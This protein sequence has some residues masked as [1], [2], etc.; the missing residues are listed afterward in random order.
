MKKEMETNKALFLRPSGDEKGIVNLFAS[1]SSASSRLQL[2]PAG[3]ACKELGLTPTCLSLDTSNVNLID[4]I[5]RPKIC[6]AG[7]LTT[8]GTS[9]RNNLAMAHLAV[10]GRLKAQRIPLIALYSDHQEYREESIRELHKDLLKLAD[11]IVFPSRAMYKKATNWISTN[12]K[13]AII[14]DPW[15][16]KPQDFY[17]IPTETIEII[18]FGHESNL[19]YL[20]PILTELDRAIP[21]NRKAVLTIL[22][23]LYGLNFIKKDLQAFRKKSQIRL[24]LIPWN[25]MQQ[26]QQL[27]EELGR[28]QFCILPSNA[29]DPN[30]SAASHN[31]LVDAIRSGCI[32]IATPLENYKELGG[33]CLLS[34]NITKSLASAIIQQ[35][36]LAL[37]Y[38]TNRGAALEKFS[39]TLNNK[40]W[41]TC[42]KGTLRN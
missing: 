9:Q 11:T 41:L 22:T 7:K 10:L 24:R 35:E 26:P 38:S 12:A 15:S 29:E 25:Q 21:N 4:S 33:L 42:I 39:P 18:W 8:K 16:T 17:P 28:A 19:P 3:N 32:T 6:I 37:K 14:L 23:S 20:K 31:R 34:D 13:K 5:G 2:I 36:R 40:S 27:E 30:K 1:S